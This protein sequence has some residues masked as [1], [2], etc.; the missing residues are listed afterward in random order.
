M[1]SYLSLPCVIGATG[2]ECI[3][4]PDVD[5]GEAYALALSAAT[6]RQAMT[7]IMQADKLSGCASSA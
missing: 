2:V 5:A 1:E 3:V 6:L 4:L 7:G